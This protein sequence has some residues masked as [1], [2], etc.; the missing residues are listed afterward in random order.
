M[1][2]HPTILVLVVFT[3]L[4]ATIVNKGGEVISLFEIEEAVMSIVKD[5]IKATLMFSLDFEVLREHVSLLAPGQMLTG[6]PEL[7]GRLQEHFHPSKWLF[8]I[9]YIVVPPRND[10]TTTQTKRYCE[11]DTPHTLNLLIYDHS[12][13]KSVSFAL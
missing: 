2:F 11:Q 5:R 1:L 6:L 7:H 13:N 3:S 4:S 10:Y 8:I 12:P 9:V